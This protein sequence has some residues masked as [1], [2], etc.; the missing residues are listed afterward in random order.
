MCGKNLGKNFIKNH[1]CSKVKHVC[2]SV[3]VWGCVAASGVG[4]LD[5]I[6]GNMNKHFYIN[7]LR[8]PLTA[9]AGKLGILQ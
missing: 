4:N 1:L 8:E 9:S 7:I 2:D 6:K 3:M 5:F